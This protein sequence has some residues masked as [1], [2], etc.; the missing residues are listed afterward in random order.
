M[1]EEKTDLYYD[2]LFRSSINYKSH[3]KESHYWVHWTQVIRFLGKNKT[4][5]ILEIG[6]GTGQF[7]EY[8]SDEGFLNYNGF[9]FSSAAIKIAA[10]RVPKYNFYLGNALHQDS[11]RDDYDVIICLEVLEHIKGDNEVIKNINIGKRIIFSVPDFKDESHVRWFI[12]PRQIKSRYYK[13]LDLKAIIKIGNIYVCSA[14]RS[15]FE[16]GLFNRILKNREKLTYYS[17][18]NRLK[19]FLDKLKTLTQ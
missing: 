11:F 4:Q 13:L 14:V 16:P 15:N 7:A 8:L 19:H 17:F 10:K 6:C 5:K 3:Y 9:D 1:G 2:D 12:S 18:S